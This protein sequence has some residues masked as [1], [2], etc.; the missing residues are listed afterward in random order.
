MRELCIREFAYI[1]QDE[2]DNE[3]NQLDLCS[4]NPEAWKYLEG[5]AY[6]NDKE[7][8]FIKSRRRKK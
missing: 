2:R 1:I 6:S 7:K 3:T 5:Y 4:V 8:R